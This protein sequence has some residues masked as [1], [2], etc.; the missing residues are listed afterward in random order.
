MNINQVKSFY[1]SK[2]PYIKQTSDFNGEDNVHSDLFELLY[3]MHA[4]VLLNC[5]DNVED[6]DGRKMMTTPHMTHLSV[7]L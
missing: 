6:E 5:N 3:L 1:I 4:L 7:E 2:W